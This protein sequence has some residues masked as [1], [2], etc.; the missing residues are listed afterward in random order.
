METQAKLSMLK[1]L[2]DIYEAE[3]KKNE[4]TK[5]QDAIKPHLEEIAAEYGVDPVDLFIDY[6]DH[7][8]IN[9]KKLNMSNGEEKSFEIDMN[10]LDGLDD[11][12][13]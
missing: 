3:L 12:R 9:S 2:D 1:K 7:V 8:A 13:F 6:M 10:N 5:V 11:M 4:Q